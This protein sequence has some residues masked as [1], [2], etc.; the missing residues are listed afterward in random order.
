MDSQGGRRPLVLRALGLTTLALLASVIFAGKASADSDI[1]TVFSF[2]AAPGQAISMTGLSVTNNGPDPAA[3]VTLEGTLPDT[4]DAGNAVTWQVF[5]AKGTPLS[6]FL[7][8]IDVLELQGPPFGAEP[9]QFTGPTTYRCDIGPLAVGEKRMLVAFPTWD[10]PIISGGRVQGNT[11]TATL[12]GGTDPDLSNNSDDFNFLN[13]AF[14]LMDDPDP[15]QRRLEIVEVS[16]PPSGVYKAGDTVTFQVTSEVVVLSYGGSFTMVAPDGVEVTCGGDAVC[17]TGGSFAYTGT[18]GRLLVSM[19]APRSSLNPDNPFPDFPLDGLFSYQGTLSVKLPDE[20]AGCQPGQQVTLDFELKQR[21]VMGGSGLAYRP[22]IMEQTSVPVECPTLTE[23]PVDSPPAGY[24]VA[25]TKRASK[26]RIG[27]GE[28]VTYRIVARNLGSGAAKNVVV[29]DRLPAGL[30]VQSTKAQRGSCTTKGQTVRCSLGALAAGQRV[31]ITVN[32]VAT[33]A[34]V[35]RNTARI[36]AAG[37]DP[38]G[39]NRASAQVRVLRP[40]IAVT[41]RASARTVRAG[42]TVTFALRVSNP[43]RYTARQVRVCDQLPDGL[44]YLR[45]T[46]KMI[47]RGGQHCWALGSLKPGAAKTVRVTVRA[48]HGAKGTKTNQVR[49]SSPDTR[50]VRAQSTVRVIG[51]PARGGGVTG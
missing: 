46:G 44:V 27:V 31:A 14:M 49:A 10:G 22:A 21:P 33:R 50:S 32:A 40:R 48:L 45:S 5:V 30:R 18:P 20:P 51:T 15:S 3:G 9:C 36:D 12:V 4:D 24:D 17:L 6:T 42:E 8:G 43:S 28:Q 13:N 38:Q 23:S 35:M 37:S 7:V 16:P 34:G 39:N 47:L 25:V 29:T 26:S 11:Y 19:I 2:G 41:K 1:A